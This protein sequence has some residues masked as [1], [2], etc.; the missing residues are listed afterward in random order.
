MNISIFRKMSLIALFWVPAYIAIAADIENPPAANQ[1][2]TATSTAATNNN[3]NVPQPS[4]N[5][6]TLPANPATPSTGTPRA[7][8]PTGYTPGGLPA[9][10]SDNPVSSNTPASPTL[11]D[12]N[13]HISAE[14]SKIDPTLV[15]QWAQKAIQQTFT[16]DP[17]KMDAQLDKL[18]ACYTDQGWKSYIDAFKKSGNMDAIKAQKL[19]MSSL[20]GGQATITQIKENQW[21]VVIPL[22][23]VYQNAQEK[24]S[25]ILTINLVVSRKMSGDL[26]IIQVVAS[27]RQT[28]TT[29]TNNAATA[30]DN[31]KII[32]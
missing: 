17:E 23:V 3:N 24:I 12:C 16:L 28:V 8:P 21:K 29:N 27:P 18:K 15:M 9:P 14:K 10:S 19:N 25:Q 6:P 22:D 7:T 32:P 11:L 26:G 4:A 20:V 13:Y 31:K 30:Q 2:K 1:I 5:T